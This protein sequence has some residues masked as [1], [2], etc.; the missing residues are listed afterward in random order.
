MDG[1]EMLRQML[2]LYPAYAILLTSHG[3]FQRQLFFHRL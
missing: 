2:R 3:V 1:L